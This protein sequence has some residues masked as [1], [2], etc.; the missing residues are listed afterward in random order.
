MVLFQRKSSLP[1]LLWD[2][3][4]CISIIGIWPRFIEPNLLFTTSLELPI[5]HLPSQFDGFKIL[6]F[7]DI[8][9]SETTSQNFLSRV[10]QKIQKER[11]NLILIG[12]DFLTH[13]QPSGKSRLVHFLKSL[14]SSHGIFACL[15]NHDYEEYVTLGDDGLYTTKQKSSSSI[16][17]GFKRLFSQ[18][19]IV[20]NRNETS[21]D[22]V[23]SAHKELKA[24][25]E[26]S[27]VILLENEFQDLFVDGA[28]LQIGATGDIMAGKCSPETLFSTWD[29]NSPGI[30]LSHNPDSWDL[31][32][33]YPGD[34]YLFGHTHGGQVNIPF[35]RKRLAPVMHSQMI[36][37]LF[38]E[39]DPHL[40]QLYVSRG[41]GSTFPFRWFSPPELVAIT[42]RQHASIPILSKLFKPAFLLTKSSLSAYTSSS[43]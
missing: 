11:P 1:N 21:R 18:K 43:I 33:N 8:H 16:V 3:W 20:Q 28:K 30:I 9:V 24:V 23:L 17:T 6:F 4:C 26:E 34:L 41:I 5:E 32:K 38:T 12:G 27:G 15:G 29:I 10:A 42:L 31:L 37:G 35:M 40:R 13:A 22:R 14:S 39:Q 19:P 2:V 7:S 36:R 25:L